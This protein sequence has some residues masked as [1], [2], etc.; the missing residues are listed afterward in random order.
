MT[1]SDTKKMWLFLYA[2]GGRWTGKE[3]REGALLS[4]KFP[5]IL[6]QNMAHRGYVIRHPKTEHSKRVTF[7]VADECKIPT[8]VTLA[9]ISERKAA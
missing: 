4:C 3:A 1:D 6:L 5:R 8:G 9:D 2:S 7:E